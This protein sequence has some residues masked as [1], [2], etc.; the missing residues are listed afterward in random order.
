MGVCFA[1]CGSGATNL[2]T[3]IATAQIDS[4]PIV[5]VTGQVTRAAIG[6]DAF[7]KTDIFGIILPIVKNSYK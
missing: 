2:M 6:T 3:D 7:Q 4:I 1:T 5:V